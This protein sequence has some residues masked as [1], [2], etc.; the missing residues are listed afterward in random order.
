M[1]KA[2]SP[3]YSH[4]LACC[5]YGCKLSIHTHHHH[6]A[7]NIISYIDTEYKHKAKGSFN[8]ISIDTLK[9]KYICKVIHRKN[10]MGAELV[11]CK[12]IH[13]TDSSV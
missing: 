7:N 10:G 11:L 5:V 13:I 3:C 1:C 9:V 4:A 8:D 6:Q 2:P 12:L